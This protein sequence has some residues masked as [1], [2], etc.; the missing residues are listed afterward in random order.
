MTKNMADCPLR[1]HGIGG[2]EGKPY[3]SKN[4]AQF[5]GEYTR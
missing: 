1:I 2:E 3:Y 5:L 4:K